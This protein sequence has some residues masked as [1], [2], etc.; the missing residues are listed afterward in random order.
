MP[1]RIIPVPDCGEIPIING[2]SGKQGLDFVLFGF[3]QRKNLLHGIGSVIDG[4][5]LLKLTLVVRLQYLGEF[6]TFLRVQIV[7]P[8]I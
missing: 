1:A 7:D 6:G 3:M 5:H 2:H 4:G 8:A